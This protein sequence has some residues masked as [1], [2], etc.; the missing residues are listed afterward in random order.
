MEQIN[1]DLNGTEEID[2]QNWK[3]IVN[4]QAFIRLFKNNIPEEVKSKINKL[5]LPNILN[6]LSNAPL[7]IIEGIIKQNEE[8]LKNTAINQQ[9]INQISPYIIIGKIETIKFNNNYNYNDNNINDIIEYNTLKDIAISNYINIFIKET[10]ETTQ[11]IINTEVLNYNYG[12]DN[13]IMLS[14]EF[15]DRIRQIKSIIYEYTTEKWE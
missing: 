13:T 2:E 4:E 12:E 11:I 8:N 15:K 1:K 5:K 6:L 9:L 10:I 3:K 14:N 7:H